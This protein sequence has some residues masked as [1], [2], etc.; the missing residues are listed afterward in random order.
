MFD[1][2]GFG[3]E[4]GPSYNPLL[5]KADGYNVETLDHAN[6]TDLRQK[7]ATTHGI[8][9]SKIEDVD[10]VSDGR[11]MHEVIGEKGRYDF[12]VASHVIEHTPDMLGFLQDCEALLKPDGV[13]VLAVP[14]IRFCFDRYKPITSIGEIVQA[15][16]EKRTRH[17]LASLFDH[18]AY[19]CEVD[20]A[21]GWPQ[22]DTRE[23]ALKYD[24]PKPGRFIADHSDGRYVDSHAWQFTP[25]SFR[26]IIEA[27]HQMGQLRF[28]EA[29]F[30]GSDIFEVFAVLS[31]TGQGPGMTRQELL[32]ASLDEAASVAPA[33]RALEA[34]SASAASLLKRAENLEVLLTGERTQQEALL[35]KAA[36]LQDRVMELEILFKAE[37]DLRQSLESSTSWRMTSPLRSIVNA[38]RR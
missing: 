6:G 13:I 8:D 20:G 9:P 15:H 19:F 26:M 34:S 25:S 29:A 27:L 7:Y 12:I 4:I 21:A 22:A 28:R 36:A 1:A 10:H 16:H 38:V 33:Y 32:L 2:S 18:I 24:L 30:A 11:P 35:A 31:T 14:D 17:T 3:L 23:A 5:P 37:S